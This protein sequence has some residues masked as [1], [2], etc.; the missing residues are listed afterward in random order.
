[1]ISEIETLKQWVNEAKKI[2]F[3]GRRGASRLIYY[4]CMQCI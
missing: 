3:F 2:V 4:L 1:M